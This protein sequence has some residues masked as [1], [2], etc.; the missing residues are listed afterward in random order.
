[1]C[2]LDCALPSPFFHCDG[3]ACHPEKQRPSCACVCVPLFSSVRLC[4]LRH[5]R[6]L[7]S[8]SLTPALTSSST[9]HISSFLCSFFFCFVF[10][11]K[12]LCFLGKVCVYTSI[13]YKVLVLLLF[14]YALFFIAGSIRQHSLHLLIQSSDT[15]PSIETRFY[16]FFCQ[17]CILYI[18]IYIPSNH[19]YFRSSRQNTGLTAL[20]QIILESRTLFSLLTFIITVE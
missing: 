1:M 12:L 8:S 2:A 10:F 19:T 17:N 18:Y 16:L 14:T 3:C 15:R 11:F 20:S 5:T 7:T 4:V 13:Q 6:L 9:L